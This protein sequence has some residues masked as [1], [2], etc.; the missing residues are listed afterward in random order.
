MSEHLWCCAC[1]ITVD[2]VHYARVPVQNSHN[3]SIVVTCV[4]SVFRWEVDDTC[5]RLGYCAA[6]RDNSLPTYSGHSVWTNRLSRNVGKELPLLA[7]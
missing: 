1:G 2:D 4:F 7:A 6:S 5:A 3:L